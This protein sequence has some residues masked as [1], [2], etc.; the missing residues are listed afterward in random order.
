MKGRKLLALSFQKSE[1]A[2]K[3]CFFCVTKSPLVRASSK[4]VKYADCEG[5]ASFEENEIK[6]AKTL[7]IDGNVDFSVGNIIF[8]GDVIVYGSIINGFKVSAQGNVMVFNDV[9]CSQEG[10]L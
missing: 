6:V 9:I 2:W 4:L 7:V 1:S 3:F 8:P 5:V 10:L